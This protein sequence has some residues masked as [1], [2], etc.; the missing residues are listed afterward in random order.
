MRNG[1]GTLTFENGES[2]TGKFEGDRIE[3]E[4]IFHGHSRTIHGYWS[5]DQLKSVL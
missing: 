2:F 4:G 3:G 1:K 5:Q